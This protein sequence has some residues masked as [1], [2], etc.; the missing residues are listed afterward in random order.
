MLKSSPTKK[1]NVRQKKEKVLIFM[2]NGRGKTCGGSMV[3][4]VCVFW[5]SLCVQVL[6]DTLQVKQLN[7]L[8]CPDSVARYLWALWLGYVP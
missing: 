2:K 8:V 4:S 7:R 6:L 3:I 5:D 1:K